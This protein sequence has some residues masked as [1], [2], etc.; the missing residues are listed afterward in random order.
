M[1]IAYLCADRGIPLGGRKGASVHVRSLSA[2]LARR[3][4]QVLLT[5][6]RIDGDDATVAGVDVARLPAEDKQMAWLRAVLREFP[7]DTLLERYSL[8][9]GP[10]LAVAR[11]L[12]IPY[13][14]E[15][16]A[17][18]VAEAI[19]HRGLKDPRGRLAE[20]ERHLIASAD[21]VVAVS[22]ALAEYAVACGAPATRIAV[23][24][25]GVDVAVFGNS[26]GRMVRERYG[27]SD[28]VIGFAGSLKP[29]HGVRS[30]VEATARVS[31]P[32][33]LLIVG[34]GPEREAIRWAARHLAPG[35][36]AVLT[37]EVAHDQVP[38]FLAAMDIGAAPFEP[39]PGFYFSP[40]KIAEYLAAGL[41]VVCTSQGDLP[42]IVGDAG[43]LVTP[44]DSIELI[45]ALERLVRD[46]P[47]RA[48]MSHAARRQA[49]QMSWE[50]VAE[51][52]E[53]ALAGEPVPA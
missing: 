45:R 22:S 53:A 36:R 38:D 17:P 19:R 24:H 6:R 42:T 33:S 18:L 9:T 12:G 52:V 10:A 29:W 32:V 13:V 14:L 23:I 51:R 4:H 47:T 3:G 27:L 28:V 37:G 26:D 50:R 21:R 39:E 49:E 20:R 11:Q 2:S 30:L 7:A 35:Q 8:S 1:R 25:N 48:R 44:G 16:N 46:R 5:C 43:M 40:L 41:P 15:L 34:D 31:A